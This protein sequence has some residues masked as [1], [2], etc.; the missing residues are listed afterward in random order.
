MGVA[1]RSSAQPMSKKEIFI[2]PEE[3]NVGSMGIEKNSGA[4]EERSVM[5]TRIKIH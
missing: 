5:T 4:P 1:Y 2:A 3:R